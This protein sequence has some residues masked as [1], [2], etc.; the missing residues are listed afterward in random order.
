MPTNTTKRILIVDDHP[1]MREGL[2]A[3]IGRERDLDV[4]GEAETASEALEAALRLRPDLV[5]VD[6]ALPG[7]NGLELIKDL[8]AIDAALPILV[9]S[10]HDELLWAERV[11]RAGARGYV[12]KREAGPIMIEAIRRVLGGRLY[13]TEKVSSRIVE[14]LAGRQVKASPIVQLSDREFEIF[15]HIGGGKGTMEIA[16][17]LHVSPKTV[18]AHRAKIK[19]KLNLRTI[20]E[21]ISFACRWL[22]G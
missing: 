8:H 22:G 3:L 9:V 2:R 16:E 21:L 20:P 17:A 18:E 14:R 12:M 5:L 15:Q 10:M 11:F 4:C 7:R 19:E 13:V 1:M 6:I